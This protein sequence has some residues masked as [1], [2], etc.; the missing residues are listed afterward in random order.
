MLSERELQAIVD[1][2]V[3]SRLEFVKEKGVGAVGP[4]MGVVMKKVRGK[5][6][7]KLVNQVL[8]ENILSVLQ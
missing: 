1:D 6:D 3:Q 4:L 5:A 8:R 2:V 7:G